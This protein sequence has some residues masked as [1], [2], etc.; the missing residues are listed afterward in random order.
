MHSNHSKFILAVATGA[1]LALPSSALARSGSDTS[2]R[3]HKRAR[4]S[5]ACRAHPKR[6]CRSRAK[7]RSKTRT[8]T[9]G[10]R[11][12]AHDTFPSWT[13]THHHPTPAPT[14]APT[15]PPPPAPTPAVETDPGVVT[16]AAPTLAITGVTYYVSPSGS[17]SN[18]GTSPGS[19]WRS[20]GRV[21]RATLRPG[22][23][24]L[25]E[26]GASFSDTTLMPGVSGASG[27]PII[28]GS[29]GT[30]QGILP[31]GVWFNGR[32]HLAFEHLQ[33]G[34]V[35]EFQGTGE[36]IV[37]EWCSLGNDGLALHAMGNSWVI[38]DNTVEHTGNSG[39]LL[40]GENYTVAGNLIAH[41]GL[42]TSIPY[43]KHGIYLKVVNAVVADNT[44]TDFSDAGISV[45]Y[46]NSLVV[47]NH[48][49][50]GPIGLAWFQ[51][52][53]IAG[54][55]HWL[56]NTITATTDA[57]IYVSPSDIGGNTRE[58]FVIERNT[59]NVTSGAVMDLKTT[60][61][62]YTVAENTVL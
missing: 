35:G 61:G 9:R 60:S 40:E 29:Y 4:Q 24:V 38:D 8:K 23:G 46:R 56:E 20:V 14:P 30:G 25:F 6:A 42:N 17:D 54:T 28:F 12:A 19:A 53:P 37:V 45:R 26:G 21:N 62:T 10:A 49:S 7:A 3:S 48:I 13:G 50:G 16:V 2:T 51:Y 44:I 31:Q 18:S 57:G 58:S 59:L 47:G 39:M 55:S 1:L 33:V 41:T 27:S 22:D 5:A 32:S 43:G 34:P 36:D 52:D 15:P 11:R